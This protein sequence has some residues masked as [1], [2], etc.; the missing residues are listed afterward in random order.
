MLAN[1]E[2]DLDWGITFGHLAQ[3]RGEN[4]NWYGPEPAEE[5][6]SRDVDNECDRTIRISTPE[7]NARCLKEESCKNQNHHPR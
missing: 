5:N 6:P 4:D 7:P 1:I 2:Q 3:C